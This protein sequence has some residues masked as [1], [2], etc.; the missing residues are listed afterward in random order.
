MATSSIP[1]AIDWLVSNARGLSA[2]AAPAAVYDGWPDGRADTALVVGMTPDDPETGDTPVWAQV[3]ANTTWEQVSVPCV[4]WA[5]RGGSNMKTARD[6]AF[7]VLDAMDGMLRTDPTL[8]GSVRSGAALLT[9]VRVMQTDGAL[10]AG[11]G[12]MCEIRF[13]IVYKSRSTA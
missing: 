12:R 9:S 8:G 11:D 4:I 5:Y 3:G 2:L 13:E 10:E 1:A 6:A 7:G